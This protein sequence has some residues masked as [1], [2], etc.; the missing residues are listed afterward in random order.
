MHADA[1]ARRR[2]RA[3]AGAARDQARRRARASTCCRSTNTDQSVDLDLINNIMRLPY[4]QRLSLILN[5][6]G[7]GLAGRGTELN[8]GDPPRRPGAQAA[9]PGPE[10]PGVA[11]QGA[12]RARAQLRHRA[13]AA[14][15]RAPP[16]LRLHQALELGRARRPPSAATP[17][18]PTSRSSRASCTSSR[19]TMRASAGCR[20]GDPGVHRPRR[21]RATDINRMII[22]LGPFSTAGI[23]AVKSLGDAS[24][25]G[26][27]ACQGRAAGR[28]GPAAAG[29]DR[30]AASPRP[31]R[32]CCSSFK[33]APGIQR[34]LDYIFY[35]VAAVNG[36]D[37]F[38]HYLRARLIL[39]TCSRYYT[40]PVD[41]CSS[42]S[43]RRPP[44]RRARAP[45]RPATPTR[46]CAARPRRCRARTPT[47]PRRCRR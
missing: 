5:E 44:S 40:T 11:E 36:F 12:R 16:R 46:S 29:D 34:L 3:A 32:R 27:P 38:G 33:K 24:V 20:R 45:R 30:Q 7:T 8:A 35:Q 28:Q 14:R 31:R 4:R 18:R 2:R 1:A 23:P 21:R 39:N 22:A 43:P 25:I 47:R 6:L 9:R 41:G 10:D 15:P 26:T 42:R 13:G 17:S 37:K 19:P